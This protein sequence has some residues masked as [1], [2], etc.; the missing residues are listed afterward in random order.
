MVF[1]PVQKM[2]GAFDVSPGQRRRGLH[3]QR[4]IQ[5]G[6]MNGLP[7]NAAEEQKPVLLQIRGIIGCGFSGISNGFQQLQS[8]GRPP[9]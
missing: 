7:R 8:V 5:A 9:A 2:G 4:F 1:R 6:Q 3:N